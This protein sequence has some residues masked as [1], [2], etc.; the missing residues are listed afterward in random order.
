MSKL[1]DEQ[2]IEAVKLY[3]TGEWTHQQ[4]GERYGVTRPAIGQLF[5]RRGIQA[6]NRNR[7]TCDEHYFDTIDS[8]WKAYFLGLLYA[9]G[10]N[11]RTKYSITIALQERDRAI[12]DHF[13]QSIQHT[14]PLYCVDY[15]PYNPNTSLQ[16]QL[17]IYSQHMSDQ[18]SRLGCVPRKANVLQ[19]PTPDQVPTIFLSPFMRGYVDGDGCI[20]N[21]GCRI[22]S[23]ES[24][25]RS[26]HAYLVSIG[27]ESGVRVDPRNSGITTEVSIRRKGHNKQFLDW[28]Y[29][30]ATIYLDRKYQR[31]M[32]YFS[33]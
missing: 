4:L 24:F 22:Y 15:K 31:Y 29:Q 7:H 2:K 25:A 33:D 23:S 8:E 3:Q 14:R 9:D 10:C 28:I 16:Y 1:T 20:D 5:K 27:I 32:Q 19:F 26:L 13:N 12:L 30:D 11:H 21:R 6:M 18:L 17:H